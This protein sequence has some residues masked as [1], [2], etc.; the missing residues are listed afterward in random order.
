MA[1]ATE[2]YSSQQAVSAGSEELANYRFDLALG[3]EITP[4]SVV[5]PIP[6]VVLRGPLD[7]ARA[8]RSRSEGGSRFHD[9]FG[10]APTEAGS[11]DVEFASPAGST[12]PGEL[13]GLLGDVRAELV[14][15]SAAEEV[16]LRE[17]RDVLDAVPDLNYDLVRAI[18]ADAN[19][20][21]EGSPPGDGESSWGVNR[22]G[23]HNGNKSWGDGVTVAV[24]DTGVSLH[25]AFAHLGADDFL[26]R[27]FPEGRPSTSGVDDEHGHGTHCAGTIL[28]QDVGGVQIGIARG[29]S[30]LL[31]A[32][33]LGPGL[34]STAAIYAG[35]LWALS[36]G[37]D[38]ISMSIEMDFPAYRDRLVNEFR[39]PE[40]AAMA[41]ALDG[42]RQNL[43]LFDDLSEL[44]ASAAASVRSPVVVAASGN[45][46]QR[47]AFTVNTSPPAVG[48][49]FLSVG[50]T[51][52]SDKVARFSNSRPKLAAPG[53][54]IWSAKLGGGLRP[55]SGTSMAAPHVAG[56]AA[57]LAGR[58]RA[59][60]KFVDGSAIQA[61]ILETAEPL[62]ESPEDV[63]RGLARVTE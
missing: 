44:L 34:S 48:R 49:H 17:E 12:D 22:V 53:V 43:R 62:A 54:G 19:D 18:P 15:A 42:Y 29:V 40:V 28:G 60:G 9:R 33:V 32:K 21:V 59:S 31:S 14:F 27:S 23:A 16:S 35:F 46:S 4:V 5:K 1:N 56:I 36:E 7:L 24:L 61:Q 38:V 20:P 50:A 52:Q 58:M 26:R 37:A 30:R 2:P 25:Q 41:K 6:L 39:I 45:M 57:V 8:L 55:D 63:G 3:P 10:R 51:D 13:S 11:L 47:P